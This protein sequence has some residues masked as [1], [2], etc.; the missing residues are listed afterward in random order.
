MYVQVT[1]NY[2]LGNIRKDYGS[3]VGVVDLGG[4]SVQMAYAISEEDA[5]NSPKHVEREDV[6]V[7]NLNLLGKLYHLYVHRYG[8]MHIFQ[9]W[10]TN[11]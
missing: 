10:Q 1:I 4:G 5:K 11:K 9:M 6:Y 8:N 2:L 7:K 3:T